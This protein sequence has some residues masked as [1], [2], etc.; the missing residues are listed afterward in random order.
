M[1]WPPSASDVYTMR[2]PSGENRGCASKGIPEVSCVASPP[3]MGM[4]NRSPR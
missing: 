4:V 1:F 3:V 2:E